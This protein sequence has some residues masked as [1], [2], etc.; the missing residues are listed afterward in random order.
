VVVV[1]AAAVR[2][3]TP[4]AFGTLAPLLGLGFCGWW[5]A[6]FGIF[7]ARDAGAVP[8]GDPA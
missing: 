3:F 7:P 5:S 4:L 8:Q 1:A 2:P 6:R